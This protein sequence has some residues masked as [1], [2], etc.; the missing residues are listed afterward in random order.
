METLLKLLQVLVAGGILN[1]WILR[2]RK[3]SSYRGKSAQSLPEEFAAY[4]L[5][6]WFMYLIGALKISCAIGLII[7]LWWS[8]A[9]LPAAMVLGALMLGAVGM[10]LKVGDPLRKSLPAASLLILTALIALL[11]RSVSGTL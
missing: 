5:P 10:H 1:V 2:Y 7:G 4:G 3:G 8:P 9:T 11:S 6:R